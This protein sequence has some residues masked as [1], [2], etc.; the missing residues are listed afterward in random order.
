MKMAEGRKMPVLF[1]DRPGRV[2]LVLVV[3]APAILGGIAGLVLP[4]VP[5]LYIVIQVIAAIGG[6]L[7]GLEHRKAG[8]AALRGLGGGFFYGL[9]IVALHALSGGD[10]HH[11]LGQL[12]ILLPVITAVFGAVF[13]VIGSLVRRRMELPRAE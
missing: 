5:A 1:V 2:Q 3:L 10:D 8:E 7:A 13:A 6:L 4:P 9:A 11:Y 12:P